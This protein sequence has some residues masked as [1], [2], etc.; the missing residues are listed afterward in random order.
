VRLEMRHE[1]LEDRLLHRLALGRG[2]DDEV[3]LSE[4]GQ[5]QR[6]LDPGER[7]RLLLGGDL[8]AAH[9]AVH[10]PRHVASARSIASWLTSFSR[11]S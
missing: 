2:L 3:G 8:P 11:T 10:V 1:I 7:R 5:L 4:I 6:R 9:L